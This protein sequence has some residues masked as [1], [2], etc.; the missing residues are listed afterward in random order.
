MVH[1]TVVSTSR[2]HL[3]VGLGENRR[4]LAALEMTI[5]N[6]RLTDSGQVGITE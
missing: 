2:G 1:D 4:F 6:D 5:A 3:I